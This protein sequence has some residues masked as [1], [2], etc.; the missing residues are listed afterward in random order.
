MPA[1]S[2]VSNGIVTKIGE[3]SLP[4]CIGDANGKLL[5]QMIDKLKEASEKQLGWLVSCASRLLSTRFSMPSDPLHRTGA[6]YSLAKA[7]P[8]PDNGRGGL[9]DDDHH[10]RR[11]AD[12]RWTSMANGSVPLTPVRRTIR[13]ARTGRSQF[14]KLKR[15][16]HGYI[17]LSDHDPGDVVWFRDVSVR[18]IGSTEYRRTTWR[19]PA[20]TPRP[21]T[22][23]YPTDRKELAR[24]AVTCRPVH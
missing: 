24:I 16:T 2:C 23:S 13:H 6:I 14:A 4:R 7:A 20:Q 5:P 10:A 1:P 11:R 9:A 8:V 15:P 12:L 22:S 18:Q 19:L 17:G 3:K 21:I